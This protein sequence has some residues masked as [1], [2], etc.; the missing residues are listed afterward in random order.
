MKDKDAFTD[1]PQC[2]IIPIISEFTKRF[3][4]V[5]IRALNESGYV[6]VP[7]DQFEENK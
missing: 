6:I 3:I 7:R 5:F 4:P 2:L 1:I